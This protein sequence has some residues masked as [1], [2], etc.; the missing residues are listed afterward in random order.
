MQLRSRVATP[1]SS[2][3]SSPRFCS[4][5]DTASTFE[6]D[7]VRSSPQK[8]SIRSSPRFRSAAGTASTFQKDSAR[9]PPQKSSIRYQHL[10]RSSSRI[11]SADVT[12]EDSD[13]HS[14]TSSVLGGGSSDDDDS[15]SIS[16]DDDNDSALYA[17]EPADEDDIIV[18]QWRR[19]SYSAS[20]L[21][22][23][24][25]FSMPSYNI[26]HV[27]CRVK[28]VEPSRLCGHGIQSIQIAP[29]SVR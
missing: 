23:F 7:S 1:K 2:I 19:N 16:S 17:P 21:V 3:R 13:G 14:H 27:Y 22:L 4:A 15:S 20:T 8:S 29:L 6:E 11:C 10:S 9:S 28:Q 5:A 18:A 25:L 24:L 26:I 12:E